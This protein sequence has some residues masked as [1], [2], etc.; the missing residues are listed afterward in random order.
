M[1]TDSNAEGGKALFGASAAA[2]DTSRIYTGTAD[3]PES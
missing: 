3:W 2:I 1:I